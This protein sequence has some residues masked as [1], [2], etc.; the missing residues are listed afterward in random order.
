MLEN[1]HLGFFDGFKQ[2]K[3]IID[4]PFELSFE[5]SEISRNNFSK[6]EIEADNFLFKNEPSNL[7]RKHEFPFNSILKDERSTAIRTNNNGYLTKQLIKK[8]ENYDKF[9][10]FEKIEQILKNSNCSENILSHFKRDSRIEEGEKNLKLLQKKRKRRSK[11]NDSNKKNIFEHITKYNMGRKNLK[12]K[13][14]RKHDKFSPDNIIKKIKAK[15]FEFLII[16]V[17]NLITNNIKLKDLN[18]SIIDRLKKEKDL[19][20]LGTPIKDLLSNNIS[21]KY[22]QYAYDFNK[23]LIDSLLEKEK[24]NEALMFIFDLTFKDWIELYTMKKNVKDW[25]NLTEES[26]RKIEEHLHKM[27]E[28]EKVLKDNNNNSDYFSNFI[29]YLFNYERWFSIRR[30]RKRN[31]KQL[32]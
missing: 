26:C 3:S 8:E 5:S 11:R 6:G 1:I 27:N 25:Q 10:P 7:E 4:S 20:I 14:E 31:K 30:N 12:D 17:N 21:P 28:L 29:F 19:E 2:E 15:M 16:F 22:S 9:Y 24:N 23:K 18:Y 32:N 13:S